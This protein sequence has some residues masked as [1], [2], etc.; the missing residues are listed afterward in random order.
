MTR[1]RFVSEGQFYGAFPDALGRTT[2][3]LLAAMGERVP[4]RDVTRRAFGREQDPAR[5]GDWANQLEDY[6]AAHPAEVRAI[7]AV[8]DTVLVLN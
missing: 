1:D 3:A 4:A 2:R 6:E 5:L 7:Y 8:V